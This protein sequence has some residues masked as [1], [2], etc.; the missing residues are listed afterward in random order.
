VVESFDVMS[1]SGGT[2][3]SDDRL[4]ITGHDRGA[5]FVLALPESGS[6]LRLEGTLPITA[7]GQGIAWDRAEPGT[8]YSIIRSSRE[9]VES[10]LR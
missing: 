6:V 2:W 10:R 9:V 3:G 8:L 1:N 4:Y 5:V 7:E